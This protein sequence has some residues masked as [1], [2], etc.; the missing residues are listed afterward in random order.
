VR[1]KFFEFRPAVADPGEV[2]AEDRHRPGD[3]NPC[4]LESLAQP[5]Q[6]R[7]AAT[8]RPWSMHTQDERCSGV[9]P[10]V[11]VE[12]AA[13]VLP[14]PGRRDLIEQRGDRGVIG[15]GPWPEPAGR[16]W[17]W[18]QSLGPSSWSFA[19]STQANASDRGG[20]PPRQPS[21]PLSPRVCAQQED[22]VTGTCVAMNVYALYPCPVYET[23]GAQETR[24]DKRERRR[25]DERTD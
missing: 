5:A 10:D 13:D 3:P 23:S 22:K 14:C 19:G 4:P 21:P 2:M 1:D 25:R 9:E 12:T 18:C 17:R 16:W 11:E 20:L 6:S 15:A 7:H 24:E 8:R